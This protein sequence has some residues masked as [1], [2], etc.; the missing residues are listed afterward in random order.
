MELSSAGFFISMGGVYLGGR[1]LLADAK[2]EIGIRTLSRQK[3]EIQSVFHRMQELEELLAAGIVPPAEKW[4][5]LRELRA[6]WG[7]L[8]HESVRELRASGGAMLPTLRRLKGLADAQMRALVEARA[9]SAQALAQAMSC[10]GLV[11]AFAAALYFLLPAVREAQV[12]W[13][14]AC[15]FALACA[16][17]AALWMLAM[18]E[19]ARWAGLTRAQRP[20][21]FAAQ[22][23]GER[24]LAVVRAGQP[25]DLAW[26]SAAQLLALEAPG[27]ALAWGQS[28]WAAGETAPA[29]AS[30]AARCLIQ[31]GDSIKKAVQLGMM[32]GRPCLDRVEGVLDTLRHEIRTATDQ[33]LAVLT[34]K[35]LRPLFA[36]VAPSVLGLLAFGLYL[37]WAQIGA[38]F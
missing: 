33:Q 34:T 1:M 19:D 18:T 10:A 7:S 3:L 30:V 11:P 21:I 8:A 22:C 2:P 27:L 25:A 17:A 26:A 15:G 32:E 35:T 14:L 31:A 9:K 12:Q 24:F 36:L 23:A 38:T 4:E 37:S 13:F 20:W 16:G 6:P 5:A 29:H 28:V